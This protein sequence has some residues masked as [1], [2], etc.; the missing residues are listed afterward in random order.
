MNVS[1]DL[2]IMTESVMEIIS[3]TFISAYKSSLVEYNSIQRIGIVWAAHF[4]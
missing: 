1:L 3:D 2:K 4:Y